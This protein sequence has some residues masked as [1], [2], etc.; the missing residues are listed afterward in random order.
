MDRGTSWATVHGVAM[1]Q[2]SDLTRALKGPVVEGKWEAVSFPLA[3]PLF[4][5]PFLPTHILHVFAR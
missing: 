3:F 5:P 2:R 1:S 4:S